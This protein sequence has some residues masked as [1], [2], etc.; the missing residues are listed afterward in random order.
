[1]KEVEGDES[2]E[3]LM[4]DVEEEEKQK[5][6]PQNKTKPQT[7]SNNPKI[8]PTQQANILSYFSKK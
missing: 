8:A 3:E 6:C 1:M 2:D 4:L 5:S 7:K